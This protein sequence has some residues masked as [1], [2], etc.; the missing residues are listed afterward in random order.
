MCVSVFLW[1]APINLRRHLRGVHQLADKDLEKEYSIA[2]SKKLGETLYPCHQ[3]GVSVRHLRGHILRVHQ[4]IPKT[5]AYN[6]ALGAAPAHRRSQSKK[7][8]RIE[9]E[10]AIPA[11]IS[12]WLDHESRGERKIDK[13]G[14]QRH[15]T[16]V[17]GLLDANG[18]NIHDL[19]SIE[20]AEEAYKTLH[21]AFRVKKYKYGTRMVILGHLR[22]FLTWAESE[23]MIQVSRKSEHE[24]KFY[25]NLYRQKSGLQNQDRRQREWIP[26]KKAMRPIMKAVKHEHI[27]RGLLQ[28]A[29]ETVA[30]HGTDLVHALL[31][32]GMYLGCGVRTGVISNMKV[33]EA[34][35]PVKVPEGYIID[36]KS[37]KTCATYGPY[38]VT[39]TAEEYLRLKNYIQER[40]IKSEYVF[41]TKQGGKSSNANIHRFMNRFF[42]SYGLEKMNSSIMRKFLTTHVHRKG[43][44]MQ[45][46]STASLLKH[47]AKTARAHYKASQASRQ[48]M[49]ASLEIANILAQPGTSEDEV[50]DCP[51]PEI[52]NILAQPGTSEDEVYDC[53]EPEIASPTTQ[54]EEDDFGLVLERSPSPE[55]EIFP[56]TQVEADDL[57]LVLERSPSPE[58]QISPRTQVEADD[59]GLVLERS[60]SPELNPRTQMEADDL[61]LQQ[62]CPSASEKSFTI[63][64]RLRCCQRGSLCQASV[65]EVADARPKKQRRYFLPQH[66]QI[67]QEVFKDLIKY[68]WGR[69]KPLK[70]LRDAVRN[71]L[72]SPKLAP[73]I[74]HGYKSK[75]KVDLAARIYETVRATIR[76]PRYRKKYYP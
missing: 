72:N 3:C 2:R 73:I 46:E 48:A 63:L 21:D 58:L 44:E 40:T 59:L 74:N 34:L 30:R 49:R 36:V 67:I 62:E 39:A 26:S 32:W 31:A 64:T 60:P 27:S 41:C 28:N 70:T 38:K 13:P 25:M 55:L 17:N 9:S 45:I 54:V 20:K 7:R 50:Y 22:R 16:S 56:R 5:E 69:R 8:R 12:R 18:L 51:E 4:H 66:T 29:R 61:G 23:S 57:G 52:A 35:N 75:G 42:K 6:K 19:V 76:S 47:S 14:M 24:S 33:S 15:V 53:P 43:N 10:S 68:G 37:H 65:E 1:Q 11:T 71:L